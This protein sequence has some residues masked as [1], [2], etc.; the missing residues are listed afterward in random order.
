MLH[1]ILSQTVDSLYC[2]PKK[3]CWNSTFGTQIL[4]L[5]IYKNIQKLSFK[6]TDN[7]HYYVSKGPHTKLKKRESK[8]YIY[9]YV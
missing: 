2:Y 8:E 7:Q 3:S 6:T 5:I 4:R 9:I 1:V